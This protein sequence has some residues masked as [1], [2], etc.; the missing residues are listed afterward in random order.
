MTTPKLLVG[1]QRICQQIG[2]VLDIPDYAWVEKI[3]KHNYE[4]YR[5]HQIC[6]CELKRKSRKYMRL[7]KNIREQ[8]HLQYLDDICRTIDAEYDA[9]RQ[10]HANDLPKSKTATPTV[11]AE[12][13]DTT[14]PTTTDVKQPLRL[15][16]KRGLKHPFRA[17]WHVV[18]RIADTLNRRYY[19][20][21]AHRQQRQQQKRIAVPVQG[22]NLA[23]LPPSALLRYVLQAPINPKVHCTRLET[24]VNVRS[25]GDLVACNSRVP[26]GNLFRDGEVHEIYNSTMARIVKLSSLNRSYCLCDFNKAC[27]GYR[28][29]KKSGTDKK[30]ETANLPEQLQLNFDRSCNLCCKTCRAQPYVM[31]AAAKER[32]EMIV[33]KLLRSGYLDQAQELVIAGMGEVFYSPYYRQLLDT[34]TRRNRIIVLSNGTLLNADNWRLVA[35]KYDN[36]EVRISL[37]AAT[38]ATYQKLRGADFTNLMQNLTMLA[39]LRR[40]KQISKFGL[41]FVVQRENFREMPAFVKLGQSLGIDYLQFQRLNDWRTFSTQEYQERCLIIDNEY[42]DYELWCVLQDPIFR[43]PMVDLKGF[44]RY[45]DA[46]ERRYRRRY[47]KEQP[48]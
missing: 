7:G 44:Q 4:P 48:R 40:Q 39:D 46:S 24:S 18:L 35:G 42:L 26:F 22:D 25:N 1:D 11:A 13:K 36:I 38:A 43:E 19:A 41:N 12:A 3:T 17:A 31:D 47:Q 16:I 32:A 34:E 20:A 23:A 2:Y 27:K 28:F 21:Q 29:R 10:R 5:N 30:W 9:N 37:D 6:V 33:T 45:I 8:L 15:R 14:A